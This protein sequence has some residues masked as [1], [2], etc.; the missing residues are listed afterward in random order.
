MYSIL[1]YLPHLHL[2][3]LYM[4]IN[5]CSLILNSGPVFFFM[6]IVHDHVCVPLL[7][8]TSGAD[9]AIDTSESGLRDDMLM[10]IAMGGGGTGMDLTRYSVRHSLHIGLAPADLRLEP[11]DEEMAK[12]MIT[13]QSIFS[14]VYIQYAHMCILVYKIH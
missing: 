7:G 5:S 1:V 9:D 6:T 12:G 14:I 4:Y 2:H 3:V 13:H 10:S 11:A 8:L